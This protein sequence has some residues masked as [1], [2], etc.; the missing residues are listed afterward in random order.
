MCLYL[1]QRDL[2]AS[3]PA[4][5]VCR[6]V[7]PDHAARGDRCGAPFPEF[8]AYSGAF[9]QDC[10]THGCCPWL[11]HAKR[12]VP[13]FLDIHISAQSHCAFLPSGA[14]IVD[15]IGAT[16]TVN[17]DWVEIVANINARAGTSFVAA[18]VTNPNGHGASE[19]GGVSSRCVAPEVQALFDD[20]TTRS[21][22]LQYAV[23]VIQF[24][25]L[26]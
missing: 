26:A 5:S 1:A 17:E 24:G 19:H 14:P 8:A 22:A 13:R 15:F 18:P 16:E 3:S 23:D 12:F 21:L 9:I 7:G 6:R 10:H 2:F 20:E 4:H 25:Y 11:G